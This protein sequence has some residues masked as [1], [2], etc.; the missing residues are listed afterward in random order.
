VFLFAAPICRQGAPKQRQYQT[1]LAELPRR[2]L[3]E[4]PPLS[5]GPIHRGLV[6]AAEEI[7]AL[8]TVRARWSAWSL[9]CQKVATPSQR[10]VAAR[11]NA[12][13]RSLTEMRVSW[14]IRRSNCFLMRVGDDVEVSGRTRRP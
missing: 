12:R 4:S 8:E 11:R 3:T 9:P 5:R 14:S 13:G 6:E 1:A 7:A 2:V 10:V